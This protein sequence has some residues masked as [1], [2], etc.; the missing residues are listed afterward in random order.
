[1][2]G[3]CLLQPDHLALIQQWMELIEDTDGLYQVEKMASEREEKGIIHW[4]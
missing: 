2:P 3:T 4:K 1:M